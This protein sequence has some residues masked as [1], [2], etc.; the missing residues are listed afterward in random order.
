MAELQNVI[1]KTKGLTGDTLDIINTA[2]DDTSASGIYRSINILYGNNSPTSSGA[3]TVERGIQIKGD[4]SGGVSL[5]PISRSV[6][7]SSISTNGMNFLGNSSY[8]WT[9]AYFKYMPYVDG[10]PIVEWQNSTTN[11]SMKFANGS[12][13]CYGLFNITVSM[14]TAWGGMYYGTANNNI[15]FSETFI[16]TPCFMCSIGDNDVVS[17]AV[18]DQGSIYNNRYTGR[19]AFY[20]P[21]SMSNVAVRVS[22]IAAGR[23]K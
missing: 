3:P 23:W 17:A 18:M 14:T 8:P 5:I 20:C 21:V 16:N 4:A 1:K 7:S 9:Y 11:G 12:I 6:G 15:T 2:T 10:E 13:L 19:W 22:W